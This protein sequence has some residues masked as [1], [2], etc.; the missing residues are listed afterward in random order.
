M[1]ENVAGWFKYIYIKICMYNI[2]TL[3]YIYIYV[4][5]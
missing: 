1:N 3:I 4:I 5:Y 2:I